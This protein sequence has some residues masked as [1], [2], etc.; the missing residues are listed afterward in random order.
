MLVLHE[1]QGKQSYEAQAG[2]CWCLPMFSF[3]RSPLAAAGPG[4]PSMDS[5]LPLR[6]FRTPV[7]G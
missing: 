6:L 2:E 5:P 3:T 4:A 1:N 7:V